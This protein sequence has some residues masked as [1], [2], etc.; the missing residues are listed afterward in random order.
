MDKLDSHINISVSRNRSVFCVLV[1][2]AV[3]FAVFA[4]RPDDIT[5][6]ESK[7]SDTTAADTARKDTLPADTIVTDTAGVDTTVIDTVA[8]DTLHF[9]TIPDIPR[10]PDDTARNLAYLFDINDLPVVT[11]QVTEAD[12]NQYLTNFD[13]NPDNTLYVP[14]AFTFEKG[15][16]RIFYRDSVGLRPR[17]NTSRRRPEGYPGE[18]HNRT[19]PDWHHAHFGI[20]FTEY[21]S[22]QRFFG[23]DRIVLKWFNNDPTYCREIYCYDLFRRFGVWSAPRASYCRL[24]IHVKGDSQKAYFGIYEM[25]EGVRKGYLDDRRK[26]GYLPDTQGNLWKAAYGNQGPADLFNTDQSR[27]GVADEQHSYTYSLKTTKSLGLPA[28]KTQLVGFINGMMPLPSGSDQ[29]KE[30][31]T[32]HIDIDLFLRQLAVNVMVGMWDDYWV[33]G[34]NY[35]FYFDL[36][37][38]FYFI[39]YD[40]DN[41]L[42]TS[43]ILNDSGTQDLLHWGSRDGDRLLVK[44]VL[45]IKEFENTYKQYIKQLAASDE[46]FAPE[47]SKARISQFQNLVRPYIANDTGEDMEMY[48]QPAPWSNQPQYRLLS[49]SQHTNFFITKINSI[50]F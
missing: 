40:Y 10:D 12:W 21:E 43:S 36:N 2:M 1:L 46:L 16:G 25:L 19:N 29:L 27:M 45:S 32:Q 8:A 28:A 18:H 41:T 11:I 14:A 26:D 33:N 35:Y 9:D 15:D 31:L 44:K 6:P 22:G 3:M 13:N 39:P 24:Y 4:C 42:G 48:D 37:S 34:N 47:G 20:K 30:W 5:P 38:R 50:N 49:G 7:P 23:M 17:G